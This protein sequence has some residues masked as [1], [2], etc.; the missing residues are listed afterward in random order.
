MSAAYQGRNGAVLVPL[1]DADT[2]AQLVAKGDL[3]AYEAPEVLEAE[4]GEV[5]L[6]KLK[7]EE[8]KAFAAENE[9]DLGQAAKKAEILAVITA[10]LDSTEND[11]ADESGDADSTESQD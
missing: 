4:V 11:D 8:L 6:E 5:P 1:V 9:I 10:A 2:L 7:V 3:V